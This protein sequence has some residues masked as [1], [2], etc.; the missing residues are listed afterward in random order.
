[1]RLGVKTFVETDLVPSDRVGVTNINCTFTATDVVHNSLLV[2]L[3]LTERKKM[4]CAVYVCLTSGPM[5][6]VCVV[7]SV[8]WQSFIFRAALALACIQNK[9]ATISWVQHLT[10]KQHQI[11]I[12]QRK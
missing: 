1:M 6:S 10:K 7:W 3:C 12:K 2:C 8:I 11:Q 5:C 9:S 4:V